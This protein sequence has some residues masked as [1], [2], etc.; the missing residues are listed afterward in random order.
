MKNSWD[1]FISY[2]S[3]NKIAA[4]ALV[5]ELEANGVTC[6]IAPRN[7]KP[8]SDYGEEI[9]CGI[10]ES[11]L[12]VMVFSAYANDSK[13]V[14][15]ELDLA[16]GAS[17]TIVPLKID[18]TLPTGGMKY[19]LGTVQWVE[20]RNANLNGEVIKD[21]LTVLST[22]KKLE[23][24]D[25]TGKKVKDDSRLIEIDCGSGVKLELTLIPAGTFL[26][27]SP[28]TEKDRCVNET[29]HQVTLTKPF[30][31]GIYLVTQTQYEAVMKKDPSFYKGTNLPVDNICWHDAAAFC[32]TLSQKTNR[33]FRL[34]TEA[35]YEYACRA[36]TTTPFNTGEFLSLKQANYEESG[37]GQTTP[38]D[39]YRPNTWGLYDMHGN[40]WEWCHDWFE[41][42]PNYQINDPKGPDSSKYRVLRGGSWFNTPQRCRSAFRY[43]SL[44]GYRLSFLGF[45]VALTE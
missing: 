19:R 20:A 17:K 12:F 41:E 31:L 10:E 30:Y 13:H 32:E 18:D 8:G 40:L 36:G 39:M 5:D 44:P 22:I 23:A 6:W 3:E 45:R 25:A 24:V 21:M 27:G 37:E 14:K 4:D 11:S 34:P 7:I 16:V 26:M 29:Q 9:V 15:R 42:Y 28:M 35:E 33:K 43:W 2:A 1:I 38:V